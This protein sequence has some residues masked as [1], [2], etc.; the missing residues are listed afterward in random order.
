MVLAEGQATYVR[1]FA[2]VR[3]KAVTVRSEVH[4]G[5]YSLQKGM[6]IEK[7]SVLGLEGTGTD[8]NIQVEARI[9]PPLLQ[10][11]G[12]TSRLLVTTRCCTGTTASRRSKKSVSVE[13]GGL[14]LPLGKSFTMT[15]NMHIRSLG[16][17]AVYCPSICI[18]S[19]VVPY[20]HMSDLD[21]SSR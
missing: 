5:S 10:R 16:K 4:M 9:I 7:V 18:C 20:F 11:P 15:W 17:Q 2:S 13:V 6:V 8:L 19:S 12:L 21:G 14:A 3:R 1:F